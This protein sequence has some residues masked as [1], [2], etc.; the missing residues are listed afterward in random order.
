MSAK[1]NYFRLGLF[2]LAAVALLLAGVFLLGAGEWFKE[3]MPAETYFEESVQGLEVGTAVKYRGVPIGKVTMI[4]FA[5]LKYEKAKWSDENRVAPYVWVKLALDIG[6]FAPMTHQEAARRLEIMA[7]KGLRLRLAS[8]GLA[9]PAYLEATMLD[10]KAYPALPIAWKP[11]SLYLPSAPSTLTSIVTAIE[12][13][14]S[15]LEQARIDKVI[16]NID[17]LVLNVDK[18]VTDLKVPELQEQM[19]ALLKEV[20]ASNDVLQKTISSPR[21][22]QAIDDLAA[23]SASL[24][25]IFQGGEKDLKATVADLPQISAN[26]NTTSKRL[27]DLL[28]DPKLDKMIDGLSKTADNAAPAVLEMRKILRE[29]SNLLSNQSQDIEA[30]IRGLRQVTENVEALSEDAKDNP[31]RLLFGEPPPRQ[32][33]GERK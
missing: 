28:A 20:R 29:L 15:Q 1:A 6:K 8:S 22:N 26:L 31:S 19:V 24:K 14:S 33:T 18:A 17:K 11:E 27:N 12:K 5:S 3:T 21:I 2:V 30:I 4:D 13:M 10:P 23:T 32:N 9:G 16:G 7:Q 25:G